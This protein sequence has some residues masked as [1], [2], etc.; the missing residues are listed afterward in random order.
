MLGT[1]TAGAAMF[2]ETEAYIHATASFK[3]NYNYLSRLEPVQIL[4]SEA[5]SKFNQ[6][7]IESLS[8]YF[9][10]TIT[11]LLCQLAT[12]YLENDENHNVDNHI[13][14][15]AIEIFLR[16]ERTKLMADCIKYAFTKCVDFIDKN[17]NDPELQ[18][19][20]IFTGS[21]LT[22]R[23]YADNDISRGRH[24]RGFA[25]AQIVPIEVNACH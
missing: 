1:T 21:L 16:S 13:D 12:C 19:P 14:A 24:V 17:P 11:P 7:Y 3:T 2:E 22:L 10:K 4:I 20:S 6:V 23:H 25:I 8:M 15:G 5:S 18:E 9:H